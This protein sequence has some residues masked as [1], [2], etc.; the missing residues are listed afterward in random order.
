MARI[1]TSYIQETNQVH[2][3]FLVLCA[4]RIEHVDGE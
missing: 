4:G 2:F 1:H 3:S